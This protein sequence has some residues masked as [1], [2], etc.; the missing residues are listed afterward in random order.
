[1]R[2]LGRLDPVAAAADCGQV[3][4]VGRVDGDLVSAD[5][6][7]EDDAKRIEDVRD[8]RRG[9]ALAP[10]AV[11]EVLDVAPLDLRELS[12]SERGDDVCAQ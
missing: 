9:E 11:D 5:R 6:P 7:A 8:A 3:E 1:V 2:H 10:Q 4:V 12:G